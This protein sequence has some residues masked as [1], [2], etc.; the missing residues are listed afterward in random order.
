MS[1]VGLFGDFVCL[2]SDTSEKNRYDVARILIKSSSPSL[3]GRVV[4]VKVGGAL[5]EVMA[6]SHPLTVGFRRS[7]LF[8]GAPLLY[9]PRVPT[10]TEGQSLG[11]FRPRIF[12][13]C[14]LWQGF[15]G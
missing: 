4:A 7:P 6:R 15:F 12:L 1:V 10:S 9:L 8:L 3:L 14:M 11:I 2:H 5:V 13:S